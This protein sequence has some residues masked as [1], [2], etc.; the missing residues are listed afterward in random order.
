MKATEA[1]VRKRADAQAA[2]VAAERAYHLA[3][4]AERGCRTGA[5]TRIGA[6][7]ARL[8][9]TASPKIDDFREELAQLWE[10]TK[11]IRAETETGVRRNALSDH[12]QVTRVSSN[13]P[14]LVRR[15]TKITET[16]RALDALRLEAIDE[17]ALAA[18]IEAMRA[19]IPEV[20]FEDLPVAPTAA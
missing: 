7:R 15:L 6:L 14:S 5:E 3:V 19:A 1:A 4:F 12:V 17:E 10:K 13:E 8:A 16:L 11:L 18:R 9:S 2:R 20:A